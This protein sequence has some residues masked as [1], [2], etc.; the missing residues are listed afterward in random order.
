M[1]KIQIRRGNSAALPAL[2]DGELAFTKDTGELHV[3]NSGGGYSN[4]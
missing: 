1:D 4:L 3:G 2:D